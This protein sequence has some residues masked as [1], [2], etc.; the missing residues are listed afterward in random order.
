MSL[1]MDSVI[2][3]G[4]VIMRM[5]VADDLDHEQNRMYNLWDRLG[6]IKSSIKALTLYIFVGEIKILR[7]YQRHASVIFIRILTL[8][9]KV[10]D[11]AVK[12]ARLG[13]YEEIIK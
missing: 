10:L 13:K 5:Q 7:K 2:I 8:L 3:H 6:Q 12:P 1:E 9:L 4:A 11:V